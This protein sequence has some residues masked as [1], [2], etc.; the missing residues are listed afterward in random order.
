ME[1]ILHR[2][3]SIKGLKVVGP[4]FC[5]AV[6]WFLDH[7]AFPIG[8]NSSFIAL[9]PKSLE[10][11]F[12][13]DFRPISLIG[14]VY[15]VITKILQSRL[16]LVIS[17]LISDVQTA[18]LPNRQILDG[19]FIIN[20]LLS[21]CHHKKQR[22]MIFKVD[23]AKAYDSIRWDYLEDVLCS[24]GFG[25]KWRSWIRGCLTSSMASILVNGSPTSE[26]QF[27][28]GL[29][30]GD[31]LAPYLFILVMES[32][33]LS[34]S[35]VI[36][37]GIFTGIRIDPTTMISHLFY[38]DD[39]VFIGEWSQE[40]LNGIMQML[41]CFSLLSGLSINIKKSHILGVG[42]P[43]SLVNEA[44]SRLGC[45]VM[46]V[47]FK[48]LGITVGG[49]T[50]LVKSWDDTIYKLKSRLS[51]WKLKTLSIGGPSSSLIWSL[52]NEKKI[53]WIKWTKVLAPKKHGGLGVSSFYA[54]NRAL[55]FKWMWRFLS[56]D[57]SLWFRTILAI[58]GPYGQGLAAAHPSNW[59]TII[60]EVDVLKAQDRYFWDLNGDG[61]FRVKDVRN[62]I[63]ETFL[64]KDVSPTRW[65]KSIP[66]KVNIFAWK[67][68][69]DRLP[70]R[71][72]LVSRG[73]PVPSLSCPSCN[74]VQ[75]DLGHTLFSCDLA[76]G[77]SR[78]VCRRGNLTWTPL[79]SYASWLNWFKSLRMSSSPKG[80]LGRRFFT[81]TWW[82]S[83][84]FLETSAVRVK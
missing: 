79:D 6:E 29:K 53:A 17:D 46:K 4:D 81:T 73:V 9:I 71:F 25:S 54:L 77:V 39:A 37:A 19:P 33:H 23:F 75:E 43:S 16:S 78:L 83:W 56:R 66:I 22:A 51:K 12:V 27:H 41:R 13:G 30:Q 47:P 57:N 84:E 67:V 70:T 58:H 49:N 72:N 76:I 2:M 32:L 21:R 28:R 52:E 8:C 60:K 15:K 24:F 10:P 63:D 3:E 64:P 7:A 1:S 34:F 11:K 31:P 61:D 18:F 38:A 69:L 74:I 82:V 45:S 26:F 5:T 50:S 59:S 14:C 44:A 20:E 35:R 42:I 65:V 80:V 62:L 55:L 48:Y 36:D 40:N 68:S